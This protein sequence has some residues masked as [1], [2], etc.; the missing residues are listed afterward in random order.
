M[1]RNTEK[2]VEVAAP[3]LD[4]SLA[5]RVCELFNTMLNDN[6][7]ARELCSDGQYRRVSN[8]GK[9]PLNS[10]SYFYEQAYKAAEQTA[11]EAV[12]APEKPAESSIQAAA[13]KTDFTKNLDIPVKVRIR[14]LR[15]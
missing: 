5:D 11:P 2:R 10:Q 9:A 6:V 4:K 8:V 14:K 7:K 15:K 1:T 3:V 12:I 13:L